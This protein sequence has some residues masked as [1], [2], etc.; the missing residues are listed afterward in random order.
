MILIMMGMKTYYGQ[1]HQIHVWI[2]KKRQCEW[3]CCTIMIFWLKKR[4]RLL[5]HVPHCFLFCVKGIEFLELSLPSNSPWWWFNINIK[6]WGYL[7]IH[8][9]WRRSIGDVLLALTVH[10]SI[11]FYYKLFVKV[12]FWNYFCPIWIAKQKKD[13]S[14]HVVSFMIYWKILQVGVFRSRVYV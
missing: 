5:W 8:S 10:S 1:K 9:K 3:S 7:A 2:I 12:L 11:F 13:A 14:F 4:L 6:F